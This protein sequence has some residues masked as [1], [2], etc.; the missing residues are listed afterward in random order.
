MSGDGNTTITEVTVGGNVTATSGAPIV[1]GDWVAGDNISNI[2]EAPKPEPKPKTKQHNLPFSSIGPLF[3]GRA[4]LIEQLEDATRPV[5]LI[6]QG[7]VGKSRLAI[8]HAWR[9]VGR[10]NAVLLISASSAEA[11][12]RNLAGL[13]GGNAL[14][15]PQQS[16]TKEAAQRQAVLHW[17]QANPGWLLIVD[18]VDSKEVAAEIESLLPQLGGGQVVLT[19]RLRN[20]SA[21]VKGLEVDVLEPDDARDF[22][23][24]RTAERRRKADDDVTTAQ[25]IAVED[26]GG[27]ALALEQAGAYISQ[28]RLS[29]AAYRSQWQS[30]RQMVLAWSDAQLMQYHRSLATT[31]LTSYQ[32]VDPPARTLLRRLAWFS[33]EP[34]PE[35]LLEVEVPGD[36]EAAEGAW[37][38]I[39][40]LEAYSLV[41]RSGDAP[42]FS[43]HRLVQ[44]VGR[45][46]QQQREQPEANELQAALGWLNAAFVGDPQDVRSWAL[47]DPLAPH[48]KAVAG[49][50]EAS[51]I[52]EPT[53]RVLSGLGLL[54]FSKAA[55]GEAEPLMRRALAIDEA[56]YGNDHPKVAIRLNN[57]ASLLQATNRLAE[58]EPLMRRALAID[59]ASYGNDHP[60]VA[61]DLN[62]LASL[63]QATNRL[64]EAEP[65]MRRALTIDEASYGPDHPKVAIDLNN[66]A[67]LLQAT[68]RLAEAEPLI[69]RALAIDEASNGSD[70]PKVAIRLNNLAS[71]LQATNRLAQAEPLMRRALAIDEASYGPDHPNVAI[72]LN[73]LASLL[74]ATN[75]LAEAEPLMRRAFVVF[76]KSLGLDHPNTQTVRGNYITILQEMGLSESAIQA[77]VLAL[78][79]PA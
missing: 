50:A 67:A 22:L 76:W 57:L 49:F 37:E 55:Y 44:E 75:R 42:T 21:A 25:A 63:L 16:A 66:L 36:P 1:Q 48:A 20:W 45:L 2:Y 8:E 33:S 7:G 15:L 10:C 19:T 30:Q 62:N 54:F 39:S 78:Q 69:R 26:L 41:N 29:L 13:C 34:I 59:E 35:S 64:A 79:P 53:A 60:D 61:I 6:G 17:L 24:E 4:A 46:W 68:N 77:K 38:A 58:A 74:Q 28:R 18:N 32:E 65:L 27:L 9:Q 11:L 14:D 72:Q 5:A 71:L 70:H 51:G 23:L 12:N 47:L 40:Q 43:L 52:T 31:W 56:S 73:T 3:K